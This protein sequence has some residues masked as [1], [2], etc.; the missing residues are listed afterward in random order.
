PFPNEG[1]GVAI[2]PCGWS[3]G[4]PRDA[5]F[6]RPGWNAGVHRCRRLSATCGTGDKRGRERKRC[7]AL[8]AEGLPWPLG[9]PRIPHHASRLVSGETLTPA[10]DT[11]AEAGVDSCFARTGFRLAPNDESAELTPRRNLA[12]VSGSSG[13]DA[14][15]SW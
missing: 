14:G 11:P 6:T 12:A 13:P 2:S 3:K 1:E 8:G 7:R 10:S 9:A 4:P 15:R 5:L